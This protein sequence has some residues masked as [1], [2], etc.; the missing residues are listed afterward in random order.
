MVVFLIVLVIEQARLFDDRFWVRGLDRF[1][2]HGWWFSL[3]GVAGTDELSD[4]GHYEH[5]ITLTE[6]FPAF[7]VDG[8]GDIDMTDAIEVDDNSTIFEPA[9]ELDTLFLVFSEPGGERL[10]GH[11]VM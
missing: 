1:S 10:Q 11:E 5:G 8:V 9:G 2:G 6:C 7:V 4:L 3:L